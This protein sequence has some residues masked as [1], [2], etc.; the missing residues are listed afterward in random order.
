YSLT[1][2]GS[3]IAEN[4]HQCP[5]PL[6]TTRGV[7]TLIQFLRL[8]CQLANPSSQLDGFPGVVAVS[9]HAVALS[10]GG[11]ATCAVEAAHL[12][13]VHGRRHA[14]L[15]GALGCGLTAWAFLK[16]IHGIHGVVSDLRAAPVPPVVV[17]LPTIA[18]PPS[19]TVTCSTR[20]VCSPLVRYRF[21]A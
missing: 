11:T 1:T 4:W 2:S 13:A 7:H 5:L 17:T 12:P 16:G 6:P 18:W 9:V 10:L 8:P 21:S 14:R 15:P 3:L 19:L 20:T